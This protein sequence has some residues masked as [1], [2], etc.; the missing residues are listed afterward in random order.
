MVKFLQL[1]DHICSLFTTNAKT[2]K[3]V[4]TRC[5]L[6]EANVMYMYI[7]VKIWKL[8][9][10]LWGGAGGYTI[11]VLWKLTYWRNTPCYYFLLNWINC[12]ST[13]EDLAVK[14]IIN[15]PHINTNRFKAARVKLYKENNSEESTLPDYML[16]W[17]SIYSLV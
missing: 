12:T 15:I 8:I 1:H 7:F 5:L 17:C 6:L 10:S 4:L 2:V 14:K 9:S 3:I 16:E 13:S 11:N